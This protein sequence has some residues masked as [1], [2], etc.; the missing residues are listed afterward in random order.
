MRTV[1]EVAGRGR[2]ARSATGE[3]EGA[4]RATA[5]VATCCIVRD[6]AFDMPMRRGGEGKANEMGTG[7]NGGATEEE[8]IGKAQAVLAFAYNHVL[9]QMP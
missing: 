2:G 5:Q 4:V 7:W 6:V 3:L 8:E 1:G 9:A